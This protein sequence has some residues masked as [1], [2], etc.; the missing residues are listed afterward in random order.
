[1]TANSHPNIAE[2]SGGF[3][4]TA[5]TFYEGTESAARPSNDGLYND[6]NLG[7]QC[8]SVYAPTHSSLLMQ[9]I[10][11]KHTAHKPPGGRTNKM[12]LFA[13]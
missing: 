13:F 1:M 9:A 8:K 3:I 6:V 10:Q 2:A 4:A 5:L 12:I 7:Y 11:R